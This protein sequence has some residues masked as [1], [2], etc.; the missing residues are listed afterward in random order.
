MLNNNVKIPE[1]DELV[2]NGLNDDN[3]DFFFIN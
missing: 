3:L 2:Y 1:T